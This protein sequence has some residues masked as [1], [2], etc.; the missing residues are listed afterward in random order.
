VN[1]PRNLRNES[2]TGYFT[3]ARTNASDVEIDAS[4]N[5]TGLGTAAGE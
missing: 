5:Q 1:K 3:R 2:M 4:G